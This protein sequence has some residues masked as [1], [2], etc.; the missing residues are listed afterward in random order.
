[1]AMAGLCDSKYVSL[2]F[3]H[4]LVSGRLLVGVLN[5][6]ILV[7]HTL[8]FDLWN[9]LYMCIYIYIYTHTHTHTHTRGC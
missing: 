2:Q 7:R 4:F 3:C 1:M 5:Y 8:N 9:L 6:I